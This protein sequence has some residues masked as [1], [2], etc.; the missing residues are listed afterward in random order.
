MAVVMKAK[1]IFGRGTSVQELEVISPNW[2]G[3]SFLEYQEN[4]LASLPQETIL[5]T[6]RGTVRVKLSEYPKT[7]RQ[8]PG[9]GTIIST[10]RG[11]A[12]C[13]L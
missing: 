7:Q 1:I 4:R 12:T 11:T 10:A 8:L 9:S 5:C 2:A 3:K 13:C 6:K